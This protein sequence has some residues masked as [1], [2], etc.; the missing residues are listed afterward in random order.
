MDNNHI[1]KDKVA[2]RI[3]INNEKYNENVENL[4]IYE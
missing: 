2:E 4:G 3:F 1:Y